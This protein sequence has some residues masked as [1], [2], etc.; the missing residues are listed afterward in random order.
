MNYILSGTEVLDG[1]VNTTQK[2]LVNCSFEVVD[3]NGQPVNTLTLSNLPVQ[4]NYRTNI[5]G[6]LLT[7]Q[8]DYTIEIKPGFNEP[9][10]DHEV[11]D[12]PAGKIMM[13]GQLFETIGDALAAV[14]GTDAELM[15]GEGTFILPAT[16]N[17][18]ASVSIDGAGVAKVVY[19]EGVANIDATGY[20]PQNE[21]C[22]V[23]D[24]YLR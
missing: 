4:R 7:S 3:A 11:V 2:E 23:R 17:A 1:N 14:S 10:F 9:G 24:V 15:L 22:K 5:Y 13:G 12:I 6:A 19:P 18:L 20:G 21:A 16:F 8:V